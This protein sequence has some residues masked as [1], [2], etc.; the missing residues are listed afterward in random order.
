MQDWEVDSEGD[1][2]VAECLFIEYQ[3]IRFLVILSES[4]R[5]QTNRNDSNANLQKS[6]LEN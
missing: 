2:E 4:Q 6:S 5:I 3:R 1:R